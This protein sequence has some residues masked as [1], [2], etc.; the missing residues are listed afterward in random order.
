MTKLDFFKLFGN[1]L[2]NYES[3]EFSV[4]WRYLTLMNNIRILVDIQ[5]VENS[6]L[7]SL[8]YLEELVQNILGLVKDACMRWYQCMDRYS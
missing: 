5:D 6:T 1:A 3:E 4:H 7:V 2:V 8:S